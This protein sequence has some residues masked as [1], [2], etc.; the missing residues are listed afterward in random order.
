L[1]KLKVS[2]CNLRLMVERGG[3]GGGGIEAG[4]KEGG[5]ASGLHQEPLALMTGGAAEVSFPSPLCSFSLFIAQGTGEGG[6]PSPRQPSTRS[7]C[8]CV[9]FS[10]KL[11]VLPEE[12][13]V[14]VLIYGSADKAAVWGAVCEGCNTTSFS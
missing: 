10:A 5:P 11:L 2:A 1:H 12:R 4:R 6:A 14:G 8:M 9:Y 3:G 13:K 7:V